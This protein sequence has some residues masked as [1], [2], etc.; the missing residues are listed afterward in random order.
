MRNYL[1]SWT[2]RNDFTWGTG[3]IY[4]DSMF[5]SQD[6]IKVIHQYIAYIYIYIYRGVGRGG[7]RG[8]SDPP[9]QKY[10]GGEVC[11]APP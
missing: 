7:G 5:D 6:K 4:V 8:V 1:C 2:V 3:R 11:F 9:I 10:G